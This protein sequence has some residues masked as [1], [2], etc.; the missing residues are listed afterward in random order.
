METQM[1]RVLAKGSTGDDVRALQDVLNFHIRRD[2]PLK[3]DGIFGAKTE[4]R[5]R[6]FQRSNG[7]K[8]DGLV[9]PRTNEQLFEQT[10]IA[11]PLFFMPQLTP[12]TLKGDDRFGLKPPRLI[13]QLQWPGPPALLPPPFQLGGSFSLLPSGS[14]MLPQF[15]S[16]LNALGLS[17]T[18]PTRKDPMDPFIANRQAILEMIDNLPVDSK[19]KAFI[20]SKVPN[21]VTKIEPPPT[22]FRWGVSPLFDPLD[23]KGFGVKGN[24]AFTLG[25]SQGADGKPNVTFGAWGD[26]K[27][28]LDFTGGKGQAR[29]HVQADG[30]LFLGVQGVF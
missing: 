28:F 30:Q 25:I 14:A 18:V 6:E 11:V 17:I 10:T 15:T 12:L 1:G 23:P 16:P 7:L 4:Q 21:T 20:A 19:F 9:G 22:G 29:P 13:P 2:I 5:V 3:V 27:F 8:I 26:G 24:A